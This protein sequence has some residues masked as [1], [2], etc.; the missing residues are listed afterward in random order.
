MKVISTGKILKIIIDRAFPQL[1]EIPSTLLHV[2]E[3]AAYIAYQVKSMQPD[4]EN[5]EN[6]IRIVKKEISEVEKS[7]QRFNDRQKMDM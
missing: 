6:Q 4:I 5:V 3:S 1:K 2:T 7:F